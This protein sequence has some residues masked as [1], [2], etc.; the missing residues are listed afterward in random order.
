MY[1]WNIYLQVVSFPQKEYEKC[2]S[3]YIYITAAHTVQL[4]C[5][6]IFDTEVAGRDLYNNKTNILHKHFGTTA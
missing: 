1:I 5:I 4:Y 6:Q 2:W 3:M